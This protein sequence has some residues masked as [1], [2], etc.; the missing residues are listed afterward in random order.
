MM[1]KFGTV[2]K[3][4]NFIRLKKKKQSFRVLDHN[5]QKAVSVQLYHTNMR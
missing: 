3:A 2:L 4:G 1:A 5:L